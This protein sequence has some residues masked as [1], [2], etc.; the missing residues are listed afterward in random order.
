[1]IKELTFATLE[2]KW[3]YLNYVEGHIY[4][5][6]ILSSSRS[7]YCLGIEKICKDYLYSGHVSLKTISKEEAFELMTA[8]EKLEE[9]WN[10][11]EQ[12]NF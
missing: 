1:M 2:Q 11:D 8:E 6:K 5:I 10:F 3:D 9:I 4:K 12:I 7:R